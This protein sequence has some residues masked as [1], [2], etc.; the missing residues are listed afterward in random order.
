MSI[1]LDLSLLCLVVD[2]GHSGIKPPTMTFHYGLLYGRLKG[3]KFVL[4][5]WN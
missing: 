5:D 4:G 2:I 1:D 3:I